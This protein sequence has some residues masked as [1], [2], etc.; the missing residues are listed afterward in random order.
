MVSW[1]SDQ[2]RTTLF[3][4][5]K[6]I[7]QTLYDI[8]DTV[9]LK[10]ASVDFI[11]VIS[12]KYPD[13][14]S[15]MAQIAGAFLVVVVIYQC[16]MNIT[17]KEARE[18][19]RRIIL[20]MFVAA[21]I[22]GSIGY[23]VPWFTERLAPNGE[24]SMSLA[25]IFDNGNIFEEEVIEDKK[26]GWQ[27]CGWTS[28]DQHIDWTGQLDISSWISCYNRIGTIIK[29][30]SGNY[31]DDLKINV[32]FGMNWI[33]Q[34]HTYKIVGSGYNNM[35]AVKTLLSANPTMSDDQAKEMVIGVV[36]NVF[37]YNEK[38]G[39]FMWV[40][41]EYKNQINEIPT[42]FMGV[43]V[44]AFLVVVALQML[45]RSIGL[46]FF[47]LI[48]PFASCSL[49]TKEK[50]AWKSL[51]GQMLLCITMNFVQIFT[52]VFAF[53]FI[54][55]FM[56]GTGLYNLIVIIAALLFILMVPQYISGLI[57]AQSAGLMGGMYS[58]MMGVSVARG[59]V[60]VAG[61]AVSGGVNLLKGGVK[62]VGGTINSA[63]GKSEGGSNVL[64]DGK[65]S[66]S[67]EQKKNSIGSSGTQQKGSS[68]SQNKG[69]EGTLEKGNLS[70]R[71]N[72]THIDGNDTSRASGNAGNERPSQNTPERNEGS[73]SNQKSPSQRDRMDKMRRRGD[74]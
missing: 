71:T 1:G 64:T 33:K 32:D 31:D 22:I 11:G 29:E 65:N 37:N 21:S 67:F 25:G 50:K 66:N 35:I 8:V 17:S 51:T 39:S 63:F 61:A 28:A 73:I 7:I 5:V 41:G 42:F 62:G 12:T 44:I 52:V 43:I 24:I 58:I 46:G 16:L 38:T 26:Y 59:G 49:P 10:A 74:K 69:S 4:L 45:N 13:I 2:L 56:N 54:S 47:Y 72:S 9:V 27:L 23:L 18:G 53:T 20:G 6:F 34:E 70:S 15:G 36:N 30:T 57:G 19:W 60:G 14:I 3:G 68:G 48:L 55:L 40:A